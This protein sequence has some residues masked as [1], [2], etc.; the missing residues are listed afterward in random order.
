M[1]KRKMDGLKSN[2]CM[3]LLAVAAGLS[4]GAALA[5]EAPS[6]E[7]YRRLWNE[8]RPEIDAGIERNRKR[9]V[10]LEF[11]GP[12]GRPLADVPVR[13]R[14]T[15]HD[16]LFGC[17][18]LVLGQMK[19]REAVYE[20]EFLKLFNHATTTFC[21]G[22]IEERRGEVRFAEGSREIW[23]RPPP[24]RVLAWCRK[25]GIHCK[26]QP[27]L[28]GSW[29]PKWAKDFSHDEVRELYR[30]WFRRVAERYG[31]GFDMFDVVNEAF[32]H[33]SFPLYEPEADY[34]LWAFEEAQ[35]VFPKDCKLMIN[36]ASGVNGTEAGSVPWPDSARWR[37][38][39]RK[40]ISRFRERGIR[41]DGVGLQFHLFQPGELAEVLAGR[42]WTP[43]RLIE[44]YA[45]YAALGYP[46]YIT[47]ITIPSTL[48]GRT[49]GEAIQA[50]VAANFYRLWFSIA[51]FRGIT[52]WN[53]CDGAAHRNEETPKG[54][55]LDENLREKPAYRA[56][57]G[58]IRREWMTDLSLR[59]DANGRVSFRGFKGDYEATVQEDDVSR[60]HTFRL[61]DE[62]PESCVIRLAK[63][64][65]Q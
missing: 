14:Q 48:G 13:V 55:L 41:L 28:A 27:L 24:D 63:R 30:D 3:M 52:W 26:G 6:M 60:R 45:E 53:L 58:L 7:T 31:R 32:C 36:E 16:F 54:A 18:C 62:G 43:R 46:L 56:L 39:Y 17:N 15:G 38:R 1:D 51:G 33:T 64:K 49:A 35:K 21:L 29:H 44:S 10:T 2:K 12:D 4:A 22:A 40:L 25:N 57:Y 9:D 37:T 50:E 11:S 23:R 47:E 20:A 61:T 34:V 42:H 65:E 59:T 5:A 19:E 8:V